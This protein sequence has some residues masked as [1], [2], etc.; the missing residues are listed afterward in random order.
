MK[1]LWLSH[2]LPWPPKTG[3][4]QRS[5]N[6]IRQ[7]ARRHEVSLFALNQSALLSNHEQ[8]ARGVAELES[9]CARVRVHLIRTDRSRRLWAFLAVRALMSSQPYDVHWLRSRELSNELEAISRSE[10]FDLIHIDTLGMVPFRR[11]FQGSA[12]VLN[13][14]NV[15]SQMMSR[16]AKRE[17]NVLVRSYLRNEARKLT[18]LE[19]RICP[20]VDLN[21][22]VSSL[23]SGRLRAV[24]P[25]ARVHVVDNGVDLEF[26]RP[27]RPFGRP[28]AGLVFVGGM[29]WYPNR[30]AM[31]FF[32]NDI[33]P[34]LLEDDP[35]R[36]VAIVGAHPPAQVVAASRDPRLE[37]TGFAEDVRPYMQRASIYVCPIRDGGGTRLKVLDALAMAKPLVATRLAVE[38]LVLEED[39]HYLRAET[40]AEFV[41]QIRRLEGNAGLRRHLAESGRQLVEARYS[42]DVIGRR[43]EEAYQGAVGP[44]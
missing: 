19:Q 21:I 32:V 22:T 33:W 9:I 4:L 28:G 43:L 16:R 23:D 37:V 13:H 17:R 1:L 40:P 44:P 39:R 6:L 41:A 14:H 31:L 15:E 12:S 8:V 5:H 20:E 11:F 24:A 36:T 29:N 3:M 7:A 10:T 25:D 26:F 42:W 38:G 18:H 35:R 2:V 30:E 34:A 27:N